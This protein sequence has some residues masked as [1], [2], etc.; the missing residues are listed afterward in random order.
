MSI[1]YGL[2]INLHCQKGVLSVIDI[3]KSLTKGGWSLFSEENKI[4]FTDVGDCDDFEYVS[5]SMSI[6]TFYDIIDKKKANQEVIAFALFLVEGSDKYRIDVM[7]FCDFTVLISPSDCSKK[8][9]CSHVKILDISWYL[10]RTIPFLSN[11]IMV[12]EDFAFRQHY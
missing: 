5:R 8:M 9:L 10:E 12:V 4:I 1:D 11:D 3:V 7:I 2:S 6:E